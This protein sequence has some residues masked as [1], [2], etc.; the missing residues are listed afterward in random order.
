M[1]KLNLTSEEIEN[2]L[3]L[4]TIQEKQNFYQKKVPS[5]VYTHK[6]I[7]CQIFT[8]GGKSYCGVKL[9]KAYRL[10]RS[11]KIIIVVPSDVIKKQWEKST[12]PFENIEIYIVNSYIRLPQEKKVCGILIADEIHKYLGNS[13]Y[14]SQVIPSTQY[15]YFLGLS[16][17][18]EKDMFNKLDLYGIK[19][20]Y[21]IPLE[22]GYKLGVVP[23]YV[24]YNLPV[25]LSYADKS[26]Y[27]DYC[28]KLNFAKEF[29]ISWRSK[30]LDWILP[31]ITMG[32]KLINFEGEK[33]TGN[34]LAY[35]I[36]QELN[37]SVEE[38]LKKANIHRYFMGE[39]CRLLYN[40][41]EKI[42]AFKKLYEIIPQQKKLIF[43]YKKEVASALAKEIPLSGAFH[44]GITPKNKKIVE[45]SF[46]ENEL[47]N[48]ITC[49][50]ISEGFTT[51]CK[52]AVRLFFDSKTVTSDQIK[53]RL[54]IKNEEKPDE[55]AKIITLYANDF[56]FKGLPYKSQ[57]KTWLKASQKGRMF[58]E[59]IENAE[60]IEFL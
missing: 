24:S 7:I 19:L 55:I 8:R 10:K 48:I 30:S 57:E 34:V 29:F 58:C 33:I 9:I 47:L 28:K 41:T 4:K 46:E 32:N 44:S 53:G 12:A 43:T 37:C 40:S 36:S 5:L 20:N 25:E 17:T 2:I 11:D 13:V 50:S 6:S 42:K 1:I 18:L 22:L 31:Q 56:E 27:A 23:E 60:E 49:K 39:R 16:G 35:N 45:K 54:L 15:E 3:E 38:V 59:W 26:N 14:F 21:E 51:D 52:L